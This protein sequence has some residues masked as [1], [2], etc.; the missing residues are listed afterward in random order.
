MNIAR[1]RLE[2][3]FERHH[4]GAQFDLGGSM[5]PFPPERLAAL[6]HPSPLSTRY[7]STVG[8]AALRARLAE[9]E[10]LTPDDFILTCGATEANAVALLATAR[11][12]GAVVLQN[13]VY[14]QFGSLLDGLGISFRTFSG[15]QIPRVDPDVVVV[16]L[17]SPHNPTGQLADI[18]SIAASVAETPSAVLLV[19]EVYRQI[20]ADGLGT[21]A[22]LG[23]RVLATNSFSKR[24][25]LPGWRL[26]WIA[27][28]DPEL[29]ARL[30]AWHEHLTHSSPNISEQMVVALWP[31]LN[32]VL[33]ENQQVA[34][35]NVAILGSW[36]EA[37]GDILTGKL[38]QGG[39]TTLLLPV[40]DLAG[41]DDEAL[42]F[43]LRSEANLFVVPGRFVGYP[44]TLRVGCGH[45]DPGDLNAA[46]EQLAQSIRKIA[47]EGLGG[48][49][50]PR[51]VLRAPR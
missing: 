2:V 10:G 30:L 9:L 41:A 1:S 42:A 18:A 17:N 19:D 31:T 22:Q 39:V 26:G 35:R 46:L 29:R 11:S 12:G 14:Y 44:G 16:V 15:P 45:R 48:L 6:R 37:Q 13:P 43:R 47:S 34:E 50:Y 49:R 23:V 40:G 3:W 20:R 32:A 33:T 21:A 5:V 25:G 51:H 24:W 8:S 36:L 7:S 38:P 4:A 28:R 27:C